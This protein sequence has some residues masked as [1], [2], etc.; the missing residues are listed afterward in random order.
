MLHFMKLKI[1]PE[2]GISMFNCAAVKK[3][4]LVP[5]LQSEAHSGCGTQVLIKHNVFALLRKTVMFPYTIVLRKIDSCSCQKAA[6]MSAKTVGK[7]GGSWV[8]LVSIDR[9][10]TVYRLEACEIA[11]FENVCFSCP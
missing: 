1:R 9:K 2:I 10:T 5:K 11:Y 7:D 4:R 3:Y 8:Y 6:Q